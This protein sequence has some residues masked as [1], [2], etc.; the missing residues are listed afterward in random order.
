MSCSIDESQQGFIIVQ[1]IIITWGS[2]LPG[3]SGAS[4]DDAP[5]SIP[6]EGQES[7]GSS[8]PIPASHWLRAGGRGYSLAPPPCPMGRHSKLLQIERSS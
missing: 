4:V 6:T 7:W 8:S 3:N 1:G 2:T 5:Q